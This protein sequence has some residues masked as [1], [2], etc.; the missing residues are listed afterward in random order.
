MVCGSLLEAVHIHGHLSPTKIPS[1]VFNAFQSVNSFAHLIIK[2]TKNKPT[3]AMSK[4]QENQ[5]QK[6]KKIICNSPFDKD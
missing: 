6:I 3:N 5:S 1:F 4:N 2:K